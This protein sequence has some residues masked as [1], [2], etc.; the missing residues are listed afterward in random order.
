MNRL[1]LSTGFE[2]HPKIQLPS[3]AQLVAMRDYWLERGHK[4][5][6][7]AIDNAIELIEKSTAQEL[8]A[9]FQDASELAPAMTFNGEADEVRPYRPPV[10]VCPVCGE[11]VNQFS[12]CQCDDILSGK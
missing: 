6:A 9:Q 3:K 2:F 7:A 10:D 4:E 5:T 8:A 12:H 11:P 1:H